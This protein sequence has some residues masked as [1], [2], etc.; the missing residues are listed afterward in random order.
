MQVQ[1]D[2]MAKMRNYFKAASHHRDDDLQTKTMKKYFPDF[3]AQKVDSGVIFTG[4]LQVRPEFP[5]YLVKVEYRGNLEPLISVLEPNISSKAPHRYKGGYLCLY[6]PKV[7]KWNGQKLIAKEIM[8]WTAAWIYFY[9]CWKQTGEW[10]GPEIP[11]KVKS[12]KS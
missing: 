7:F 12:M 11:H 10:Y 4:W 5:K 6:H 2:S 3:H 1:E 8:I 9:E